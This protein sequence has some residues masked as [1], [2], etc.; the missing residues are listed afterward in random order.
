MPDSH[1]A[2]RYHRRVRRVRYK[3]TGG[4]LLKA[5]SAKNKKVRIYAIFVLRHPV[6]VR[7]R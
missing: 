5:W 3:E 2:H 7:N 4:L 1:P 6:C